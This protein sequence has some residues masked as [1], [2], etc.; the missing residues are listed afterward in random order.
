[1]IYSKEEHQRYFPSSW[2]DSEFGVWEGGDFQAVPSHLKS[3]VS[4]T[5]ASGSSGRFSGVLEVGLPR[6]LFSSQPL[7]GT[8]P[9]TAP[10]PNPW[11]KCLSQRLQA[12]AQRLAV[13]SQP[14][15]RSPPC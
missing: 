7:Q 14:S 3:P 11:G 5:Q 15:V 4:C 12:E 9:L 2:E 1:M 6:G 13:P 10:R 8:L